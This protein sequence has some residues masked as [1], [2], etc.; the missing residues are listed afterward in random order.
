MEKQCEE[1]ESWTAFSLCAIIG[2]SLAK[3]YCI[4]QFDYLAFSSS[5]LVFHSLLM[6]KFSQLSWSVFFHFFF[7][8]FFSPFS[9]C[10]KRLFYL[11]FIRS[12]SILQVPF[13]EINTPSIL[14]LVEGFIWLSFNVD[15]T[16]YG[17][18]MCRRQFYIWSHLSA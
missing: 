1:K 15:C 10:R 13:I 3:G 18:R 9:L 14:G 5:H 8:S 4:I 12:L 17:V 11:I 16:W 7:Y 6:Y 2:E